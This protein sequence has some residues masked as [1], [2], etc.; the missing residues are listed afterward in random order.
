M[1]PCAAGDVAARK[2]LAGLLAAAAAPYFQSLERWLT[3]GTLDDPFGEFM[4]QEHAVRPTASWAPMLVHP[5]PLHIKTQ[6][7]IASRRR[8]TPGHVRQAP[9][10]VK[11]VTI[12][13][14]SPIPGR[15]HATTNCTSPVLTRGSGHILA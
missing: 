5:P 15:L 9:L 4:V 14:Q 7:Y 11:A 1:S 8:Q 2:L 6:H 13:G 10:G 3:T 12:P